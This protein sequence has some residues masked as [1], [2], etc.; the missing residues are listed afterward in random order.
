MRLPYQ[1][2]LE[3]VERMEE[4]VYQERDAFS[5]MRRLVQANRDAAHYTIITITIP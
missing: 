4:E 3:A 2:A 5:W 1:V